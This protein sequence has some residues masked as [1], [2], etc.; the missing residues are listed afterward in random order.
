L[1]AV[2][3]MAALTKI[4]DL[5]GFEDQVILHAGL[6]P[7]LEVVVVAALPWLELI[8]GACL[9]LG[10]AR[11]EAGL[12]TTVLLAAFLVHGL[13]TVSERDC[14]CFLFPNLLPSSQP[15]WQPARN[16]LLLAASIL[17]WTER[18]KASRA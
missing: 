13:I 14:G 7:P 2:F 18:T 4:T 12:I 9:A 11:R 1:A 15:W 8:C 17:V 3:L 5:A 10:Y 16:L 6:P